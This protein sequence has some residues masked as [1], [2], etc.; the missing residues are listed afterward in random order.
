MDDEEFENELK[1]N[2]RAITAY[3]TI[4]NMSVGARE[5]FPKDIYIE[6]DDTEEVKAEKLVKQKE[7]LKNNKTAMPMA[8]QLAGIGEG[9]NLQYYSDGHFGKGTYLAVATKDDTED[10]KET[11]E[12]CWQYGAKLGSVQLKMFLNSHARIVTNLRLEK[13]MEKL[14]NVF[15]GVYQFIVNS[16]NRVDLGVAHEKQY[17]TMM[18]ALFGYNTINSGPPGGNWHSLY[19]EETHYYV[20]TDRSALTLKRG[21]SFRSNP[22]GLSKR[23][24]ID[25]ALW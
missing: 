25:G 5:T 18:A 22:L 12:D 1:K 2:P 10:H 7:W 11:R 24:P 19:K 9:G 3:H 17:L 6:S 21:I 23:D 15:G 4:N 14:E 13:M 16:E 20:T 8:K